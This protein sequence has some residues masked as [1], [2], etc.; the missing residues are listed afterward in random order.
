MTGDQGNRD[1]YPTYDGE[2]KCAIE[3]RDNKMNGVMPD[4][5]DS[6]SVLSQTQQERRWLQQG[7]QGG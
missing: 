1:G 7:N 6:S 5:A 4:G 3:T 2:V